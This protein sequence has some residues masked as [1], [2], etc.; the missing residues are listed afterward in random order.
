MHIAIVGPIAV[1]DLK[2]VLG[3]VV[4]DLPAGHGG[5]PLMAAL[6]QELLQ[7][8]HTVTGVTQDASLP[9]HG[10]GIVRYS[11]GSLSLSI[12]PCRPRA[13]AFNGRQPGRIVDFFRFERRLIEAEL[14]RAMP[15]IVHA[16]WAYEYGLAG[17]ATGLPTLVTLHD[18]PVVVLKHTRSPYRALRLLMANRAMRQAR[19]LTAPS[20]YLAAALQLR[21][22][23]PITVVPNPLADYVVDRA[24]SKVAPQSLRLAMICN[25]WD[26]R[27]NPQLGIA[28]FQRFRANAPRAEL[29]LYG[30][31]FGHG[32]Q[33][34]KWAQSHGMAD[35]CVFH[36]S[37]PHRELIDQL[38]SM[39][40]LLHPSREESFGVVIAEAMCLGLNVV[41]GRSSGA[42]PWV[43]SSGNNDPSTQDVGSSLGMLVDVEDSASIATGIAA[44]FLDGG[45]AER[46]ERGMEKALRCFSPEA[47]GRA[48]QE[49]YESVLRESRGDKR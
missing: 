10:S 47:V 33:A 14:R 36:G 26:R 6:I 29:H 46:S 42:V 23:S 5:A 44:A 13:W 35:G 32:Q 27:K 49:L 3:A 48:Y 40:V 1:A 38:S 45:Y 24:R 25:G 41:A 12:C 16:H 11:Q 19:H 28:G 31:G 21:C 34:S 9:L 17:L 18:D 15:D 39:D 30:Y 37:T 20:D 22:E 4:R 43:L 8:G 2:P 7:L